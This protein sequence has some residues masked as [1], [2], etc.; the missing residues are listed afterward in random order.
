DERRVE[1]S[2]TLGGAIKYMQNHW[3]A[4][5]RFLEVPGA[6]LDNNL[7]ERALKKAILHR[8]N[9]LFCQTAN[10][11][12]VDDVLISLIH[13]AALD[14]PLRLPGSGTAPRRRCRRVPRALDALALC[15]D[16]GRDGRCCYDRVSSFALTAPAS[17]SDTPWGGAP[18]RDANPESPAGPKSLRSRCLAR[19]PRPPA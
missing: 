11:A 16:A 5:T 9:S 1:P 10:G 19:Q 3:E 2:S 7:V 4:L 18:A 14:Q 12:H 17:G 8:R 15:R 13:T 6:P